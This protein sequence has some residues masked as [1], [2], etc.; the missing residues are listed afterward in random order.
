MLHED[1][2]RSTLLYMFAGIGLG[3]LIGAA[4]GMLFAPKPGAELREDL[5]T[6]FEDLRGK[7]QELSSDVTQKVRQTVDKAKTTMEKGENE[8]QQTEEKAAQSG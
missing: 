3:A 6:K 8:A 7:F 2:E 5:G 4:F 1:E